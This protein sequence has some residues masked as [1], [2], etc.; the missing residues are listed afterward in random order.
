MS[1]A[2]AIG[3]VGLTSLAVGLLLLPLLSRERPP[4]SREAYNLAVYR[5]QLAEIDRDLGR[6]LLST[7]QAET[8]RAELGRRILALGGEETPLLP[9]PKPLVAAVVAILAMPV[10]ALLIYAAIGSPGLPDQPFAE[11]SEGGAGGTTDSAQQ[12]NMQEA[13]AK[14]RAHL[15]TKPEDLTGWLLLARSEVGLGRYREGA[16]AY[17]RAAELSSNRPD[18]AAEWGE[19]QV[20][21]AGSV[22][23]A[24][25]KAFEAGLKDKA[26]APKSRYYL[27]LAK[28]E[29]GDWRGALRDWS[30]L[31]AD[32]PP[33][34][35]WQPLLRQRIAEVAKAEGIDPASIAPAAAPAS[36][37]ADGNAGAAGLGGFGNAVAGDRRGDRE[38]DGR[39]LPRG[40]PR[41]D[42]EHGRA[43]RVPPRTAAGRRRGLGA[44]RPLVHGAAPAREGA[45]RLRPRRQAAAHRRGARAGPR[46][47]DAYGGSRDFRQQA[48]TKEPALLM[49]AADRS[50]LFEPLSPAGG[51]RIA[52]LD[53]S[54]P[55]SPVQVGII[56]AAILAHHVVVIAGQ[57]LTREQQAAVAANLGRVE[58]HGRERGE[59]K[60]QDVAHVMSNVDA[61]GA[62]TIRFSPAANYHW[63]TDK[64]YRP[65]PP[66][67]TLLYAVEVPPEGA[68]RGGDTEFA[69]AALAYAALP[70]DAKRRLAGLRVVFRPAF[71]PRLPEVD[72]P[73]V[74]THPET[75]RKALCI[76]NHA[77]HI[78]GMAPT[79]GAALLAELLAHATGPEFV[80]A[81][82]WRPGDLVIWDNRVLLHRLVLGDGLRLH[83]RVMHR[84]TVAGTVPF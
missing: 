49:E 2:V 67:L 60:R 84:S 83:R 46:R 36:A 55:L 52:R 33:D 31:A 44:A 29:H 26:S 28:L 42:R 50:T 5:D 68:G 45:R 58:A 40:A 80:Y 37:A 12:M 73:L 1:I 62:P 41:N 6:G 74:R 25:A 70:D 32:S 43:A 69:N 72:H 15:A 8:A 18:I 17:A 76:G 78:A 53:L 39:R 22:T 4:Q 9:S 11:R 21:A 66:S 54:R 38:G 23:P 27:A 61:D 63:H 13:L 48:V 20:L 56:R 82:R 71:D 24:A 65:A 16:E 79:E 81:H 59:K 10:A 19:A 35:A 77:T 51:V 47:R 57:S 7:G 75:G 3:L 30:D 34:A 64:P 14:L